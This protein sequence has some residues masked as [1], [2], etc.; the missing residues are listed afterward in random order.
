MGGAIDRSNLRPSSSA[1]VQGYSAS[2]AKVQG[3]SGRQRVSFMAGVE[4]ELRIPFRSEACDGLSAM[5]H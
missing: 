2:D 5:A 3:F 4:W 1:I